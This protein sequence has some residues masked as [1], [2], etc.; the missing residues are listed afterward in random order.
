MRRT[1]AI[2]TR[3]ARGTQNRGSPMTSHL[4]A[5]ASIQLP[6]SAT[7]DGSTF[8]TRSLEPPS[9]TLRRLYCIAA[10][11]PLTVR[12]TVPRTASLTGS[13]PCASRLRRS[14]LLGGPS[15]GACNFLNAP[16]P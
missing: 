6:M 12:R 5:A 4:L 14:V 1:T 10:T 8:A 16:F 11:S 7:Q 15:H 2:P 13:F 9:S 3:N